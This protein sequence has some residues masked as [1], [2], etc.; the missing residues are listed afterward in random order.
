MTEPELM[1]RPGA[2]LPTTGEVLDKI[3]VQAGIMRAEATTPEESRTAQRKF[4]LGM[5]QLK[6]A[7]LMIKHGFSAK[8]AYREFAPTR[9]DDR[10]RTE[11]W[12]HHWAS[13]P[14]VLR[15]MRRLVQLA[16]EKVKEQARLSVERV[17]QINEWMIEANACELVEQQVDA[18]GRVT[19]SQFTP[20]EKLSPQMQMSVAKIRIKDGE[21]TA[22][23]TYNRLQ[24]LVAHVTLLQL[25]EDHGGSDVNWLGQFKK[26]MTEARKRIIDE[27]IAAGKVVTMPRGSGGK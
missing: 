2:P 14:L 18:S 26:R 3:F 17:I 15:E 25:L 16:T 8:A 27:Q 24:A 10:S 23:E 6:F 22:V 12:C 13:D 5:Q 7:R 11:H 4:R 21:V 19:H 1:P 20:M 9:K